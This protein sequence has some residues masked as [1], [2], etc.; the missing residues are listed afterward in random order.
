[1][2]W[3]STIRRVGVMRRQ[4]EAAGARA[5]MTQCESEIERDSARLYSRD[6]AACEQAEDES[7]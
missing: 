3:E 4:R 7:T 6:R 1:M 2:R 5:N